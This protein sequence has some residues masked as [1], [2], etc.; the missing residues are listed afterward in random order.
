MYR[1]ATG[2]KLKDVRTRLGENGQ[3]LKKTETIKGQAPM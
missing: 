2:L 1:A 3:V